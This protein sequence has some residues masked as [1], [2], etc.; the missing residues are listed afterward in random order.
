MTTATLTARL[1]G[2][3]AETGF[4]LFSD[5]A[6][7]LDLPHNHDAAGLLLRLPSG[8]ISLIKQAGGLGIALRADNDLRLYALQ[9]VV[10]AR[11]DRLSPV[12][13]LVW[14]R[15]NAGAMPP[16]LSVVTVASITQI[17]ANFRRIRVSGPDIARFA[18]GGLHF[19]LLL[20]PPGRAPVWPRIDGTGRTIWPE[21]EDALHRPV[22]T[23]RD[24]D[25][26]G[27]WLDIDVFL[28]KGGR[29]TDWSSTAQPGQQ[30]GMMGPSGSDAPVADWIAL[31]GDETALPALAR[32][33]ASLPLTTVGHACVM[34]PDLADVQ[35]LIGPP[36][37]ALHWLTRGGP[38]T[39]L[40]KLQGLDI[41]PARRFVWF[42][43]EK[44][45]A[46]L[47]RLWLRN[48]RGLGKSESN[49]SAYWT[50]PA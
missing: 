41:P 23:V 11:L 34:V 7:Q 6:R 40:A 47:A 18:S 8:Q 26:A 3:D 31:F 5:F 39:L 14:D 42:S 46:D 15:V 44:S 24:F 19:R 16:N 27:Q 1:P 32:I 38:D 45:E 10:H 20:A 35:P 33:L 29:V 12:P 28:H 9:Q 49:I 13:Q 4:G 50:A 30:I 43:A 2:F 21:D 48:D 25:P 37:V 22:Y 36:L 17:S